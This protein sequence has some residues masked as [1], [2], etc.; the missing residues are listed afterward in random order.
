MWSTMF[1]ADDDAK[2][3][4]RSR[5]Q[6]KRTASHSSIPKQTSFSPRIGI[7]QRQSLASLRGYKIN[8]EAIPVV[9]PLSPI[10]AAEDTISKVDSTLLLPPRP[11][12]CPRL[13]SAFRD[14]A[15]K[16]ATPDSSVPS[17]ARVYSSW[18]SRNSKSPVEPPYEFPS[19]QPQP[20]RSWLP[21]ATRQ[22]PRPSYLKTARDRTTAV[23]GPD[24]PVMDNVCPPPTPDPQDHQVQLARFAQ[25]KLDPPTSPL[26]LVYDTGSDKFSLV[27]RALL[28]PNRNSENTMVEMQ[29][30]LP[31]LL[32]DGRMTIVEL[33]RWKKTMTLFSRSCDGKTTKVTKKEVDIPPWVWMARN[34]GQRQWK[35]CFIRGL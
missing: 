17:S 25:P 12:S 26:E 30:D 31:P 1:Q 32:V 28:H 29:I 2:N 35:E 27:R 16:M 15:V 7:K 11:K 22:P 4:A 24:H 34:M 6:S 9:K 19:Y 3:I 14:S 5:D 20:D 18:A 23:H 33:P 10:L 13:R 21:A 8:F